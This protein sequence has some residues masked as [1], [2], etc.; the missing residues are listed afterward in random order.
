[1]RTSG[2]GVAAVELTDLSRDFGS[3]SKRVRALREVSLSIPRGR[4][5][6]I[7]GPSGSGKS[8]LLQCAAGLD[9]PTRGRVVLGDTD[10]SALRDKE[11]TRLRG[12]Q[13]GFVFQAFNLLPMLNVADNVALPAKLA[14]QRVRRGA[15]RELLA[16]VGLEGYDRR[17]PAELSGGQQQR[18]AIARALLMRPRVVFADEPT[19]ALDLATG[20][21]ILDLLRAAVDVDGQTVVLVT[22][23]PAVAAAADSVVMLAD[24]RIQE[25]IGEPSVDRVV[26]VAGRWLG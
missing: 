10:L 18:V 9:R 5:T 11:L 24:G 16:R 25:L 3:G 17:R 13:I 19:G 20:R 1:V 26:A 22:H 23:D 7:M 4:M 12:Q 6:A 14:G 15:V 8:T 2:P 21:R